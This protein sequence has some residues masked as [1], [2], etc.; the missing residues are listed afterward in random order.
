MDY[1]VEGRV[2]PAQR[3][4]VV[5]ARDV[6]AEEVG[7]FLGDA[8]GEVFGLLGRSGVGPAGPP[9]ARYALVGEGRF[10]V[11]AGVAVLEAV[12]P[13]GR[14]EA[15]ALPSGPAAATLHE[16]PYDAVGSAYE[17]VT[18]WISAHG[19][20]PT[21]MGWE[22][23]LNDPTAGEVPRTEVVIPYRIG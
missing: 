17:A 6:G 5:R 7:P 23:Y 1:E 8:F 20:T 19:G 16:G 9:F 15:S 10:D 12:E 13:E 21:E 2:L 18:A 22:H 3:T 14:V 4:A 11:E